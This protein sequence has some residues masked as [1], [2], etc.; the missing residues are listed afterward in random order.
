MLAVRITSSVAS[1]FAPLSSSASTTAIWPSAAAAC[2]AVTP[3]CPFNTARRQSALTTDF[4]LHVE[5]LRS[6]TRFAAFTSAPLSASAATRVGS[7]PT[8]ALNSA[9]SPFCHRVQPS[10]SS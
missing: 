10:E 7:P 1:R 8:A 5:T 3:F 2:S 4:C 6:I 9:V